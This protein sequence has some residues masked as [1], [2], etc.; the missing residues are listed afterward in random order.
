MLTGGTNWLISNAVNGNLAFFQGFSPGTQWVNFDNSRSTTNVTRYTYNP[1]LTRAWGLRYTQPPAG[2]WNLSE[3]QV[4]PHSEAERTDRLAVFRQQVIDTVAGV[5]RLY[6]DLLSLNE[7][8]KVKQETLR[9]A[10]RLYQDNKNKVD[11][12]T[13]APIEVTRAQAQV[14]AS[15]QALITA[16]G[17]VRQQEL[18]VKTVIHEN[19]LVNLTIRESA[20][21]PVD[22]VTVPGK[23]CAARS[24]PVRGG[25]E[26]PPRPESGGNPVG[27]RR[28]SA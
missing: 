19:G 16:E 17:L 27:E 26:K 5:A 13:L 18:I 14:A 4:Y 21:R 2:V 7:D 11:Q 20:H 28:G 12:G 9:L 22:W 3:S 6:T 23:E 8:V 25:A 1:T 10:E 24:G 15:R